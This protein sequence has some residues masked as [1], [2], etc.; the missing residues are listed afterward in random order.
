MLRLVA[1]ASCALTAACITASES[2]T[3]EPVPIPRPKPAALK[4]APQP[5]VAAAQQ[6]DVGNI[7]AAKEWAICKLLFAEGWAR[8]PDNT[9]QG[10]LTAAYEAC[11]LKE[12]Q[13]KIELTKSGGDQTQAAEF[14]ALTR[15]KDAE[16]LATRLRAV[17][18]R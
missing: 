15:A 6:P 12:E 3:A 8:M 9:D 14:F 18:Q 13:L 1:W 2:A 11:S 10:L 4:L 17:R 5:T 7:K 16:T